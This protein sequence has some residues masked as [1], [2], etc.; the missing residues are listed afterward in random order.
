MPV[1]GHADR[2]P[3]AGQAD[4]GRE[5][6]GVVLGGPDAVPRQLNEREPQPLGAGGA[7]NVPI[8][9][10]MV[11]EDLQAAADEQDHAQEG[12]I[13]GDAQPNRKAVR[14]GRRFGGNWGAG[15]QR[16][17]TQRAPLNVSRGN[18]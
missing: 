2:V 5:M 12:D 16:R 3:V 17:E 6:A 11:H 13:V 4:P 15:R 1:P 9:P 10:R 18:H 14:L 8:K 7:V